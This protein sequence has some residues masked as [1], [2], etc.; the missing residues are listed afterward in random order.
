M[1]TLIDIKKH[2]PLSFINIFPIAK[3]I[4]LAKSSRQQ[5]TRNLYRPSLE[6]K[7]IINNTIFSKIQGDIEETTIPLTIDLIDLRS[8]SEIL[9]NE[10]KKEGVLWQS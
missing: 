3:F 2:W 7:S 8:V 4:Y 6:C 10:V 1:N 9:K 5:P